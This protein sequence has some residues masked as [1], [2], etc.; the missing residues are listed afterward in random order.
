[1]GDTEVKSLNLEFKTG[2]SL[3]FSAIVCLL[4][5]L[6]YAQQAVWARRKLRVSYLGSNPQIQIQFSMNVMSCFNVILDS[7]YLYVKWD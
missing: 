3:T 5:I 7:A 2:I 6:G 1:M 4:M